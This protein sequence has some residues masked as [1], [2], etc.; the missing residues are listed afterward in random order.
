MKKLS[1]LLVAVAL[2]AF[3]SLSACKGTA[4]P[5]AESEKH[6]HE[7]IEETPVTDTAVADTVAVAEKEMT[8]EEAQEEHGEEHAH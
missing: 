1:F 6:S 7:V 5:E 4:K 2:G 8:G 3:V